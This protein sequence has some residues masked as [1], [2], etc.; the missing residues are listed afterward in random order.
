MPFCMLDSEV[1]VKWIFER[2][3]QT[4]RKLEQVLLKTSLK[5]SIKSSSL[6]GKYKQ[7]IGV[8]RLLHSTVHTDNPVLHT[9]ID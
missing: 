3:R 5:L 1:S 6:E 4:F 7:M 8:S 2:F 9:V